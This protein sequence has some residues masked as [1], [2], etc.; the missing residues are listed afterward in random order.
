MKKADFVK[1]KRFWLLLLL[2]AIIVL[3]LCFFITTLELAWIDFKR[4]NRYDWPRNLEYNSLFWIGMCMAAVDVQILV[5][6]VV[7]WFRL[8]CSRPEKHKEITPQMWFKRFAILT[9]CVVLLTLIALWRRSIYI[10]LI[11]EQ[12]DWAWVFANRY[13]PFV[14]ADL[15]AIGAWIRWVISGMKSYFVTLKATKKT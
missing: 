9:F 13:Y 10:P 8:L 1:T 5:P 7:R 14:I 4:F 11:R 3:V 15:F 6:C 12:W 2:G